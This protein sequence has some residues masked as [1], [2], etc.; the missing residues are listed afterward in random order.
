[1]NSNRCSP[2]VNDL[3]LSHM[4]TIFKRACRAL[5]SNQRQC[6]PLKA[7]SASFKR[8]VFPAAS[9][10]SPARPFKNGRRFHL[11]L[12]LNTGSRGLREADR[13]PLAYASA[14]APCGAW[15]P[16]LWLMPPGTPSSRGLARK[17][18]RGGYWGRR[19]R[20]PL[21][22]KALVH[23]ASLAHEKSG[24]FRGRFSTV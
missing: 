12:E 22:Q 17:M 23:S 5:Q 2:S 6:P 14:L 21:R 15:R 7:S 8:R 1:M 9:S 11:C 18:G 19:V 10:F 4:Q 24:E 3:S 13:G 20:R 16:V